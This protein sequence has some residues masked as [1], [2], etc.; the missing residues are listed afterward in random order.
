[1]MEPENDITPLS[2]AAKWGLIVLAVATVVV[3][4]GVAPAA[5]Q[6][7]DGDGE[8][9]VNAPET[10]VDRASNTTIPV[11]IDSPDGVDP[12]A[13]EYTLA[14]NS[15][16]LSVAGVTSGDYFDDAFYSGSAVNADRE[17]IRYVEFQGEGVS[18]ADGTVTEIDVRAD[19]GF[20]GDVTSEIKVDGALVYYYGEDDVED[21]RPTT[22]AGSVD[23]NTRPNMEANISGIE[24]DTGT[25]SINASDSVEITELSVTDDDGDDRLDEAESIDDTEAEDFAFDLNTTSTPEKL[26]AEITVEDTAGSTIAATTS[27]EQ[28][29]PDADESAT[30]Q[31]GDG[32]TEIEVETSEDGTTA[33]ASVTE[34]DTPPISTDPPSNP[35]VGSYVQ[36]NSIDVDIETATV[37]IQNTEGY[38]DADEVDMVYYTED[39]DSG[40]STDEVENV[41]IETV[42]GTEYISGDVSGF[43]TIAA[44]EV[45]SDPDEEIDDSPSLG[46]GG[47]GGGGGLAGDSGP[48]SFDQLRSTLR[49]VSPEQNS[50]APIEDVE[51]EQDGLVVTTDEADSVEQINF[52]EESLTGSVS[53]TEY[54]NPPQTIA[55]DVIESAARDIDT[56]DSGSEY[57]EPDANVEM[58]SLADI[59]PT[60]EATEDSSATVAL[61]VD[62]ST[63]E[64]PEQLTVLKETYSF[65]AQQ[66]EWQQREPTIQE[67][68]NG[69][70]RLQVDVESFS[71]FAIV[72]T[73]TEQT[74]GDDTAPTN[75]ASGLDIGGQS[76]FIIAAGVVLA[77]LITVLLAR[78]LQSNSDESEFEWD[79]LN[80]K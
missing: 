59:T 55:D 32:G 22:T 34:S 1:M 25:L 43:S 39:T 70:I 58:V 7:A 67:T 73:E 17:T 37:R 29:T 53:V 77:L 18:A 64:N 72:E 68:D 44:V 76:L 71:L 35:V 15:T 9:T 41:R 52:N 75:E 11:Q 61:T 28:F 26:T 46:G 63:V 49:L 65:E 23:I 74:S 24:D 27:V 47:G 20:G 56:V 2:V 5:A 66:W 79:P 80:K 40:F 42:D 30:I 13:V 21:F 51:P 33:N 31:V 69:K 14:Y 4:G 10:T 8:L 60:V 78:R 3:I 45:S 48:P 19:S 16:E 62:S 36:V 50:E 12:A 54:G 38:E 6:A 57:G